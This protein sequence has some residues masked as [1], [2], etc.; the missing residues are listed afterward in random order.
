MM[1]E[2]LL[3]VTKGGED[4]D[5]GFTYILELAKT[6][7]TGIAMLMVYHRRMV[8]TYED[9]MAAVAFAEAGVPE[10][11][12]ELMDAQNKSIKEASDKKINEMT[13]KCR[14]SSVPFI[15][16]IAVDDTV[17][18]IK[19][20]L[21]TRPAI[22]MILLSPSLAVNKKG[23]DLKKLLKNITKPVVTLSAPAKAGA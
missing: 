4:C 22:D 14:E 2:K 16:E 15:Y 5:N 1:K 6:L 11:V 21:K 19:N 8:E 13:E 18:A 10:T 9:V 3:F 17:N 7:N 23:F 12:K 20:F